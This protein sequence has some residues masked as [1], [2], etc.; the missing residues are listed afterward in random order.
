MTGI[1]DKIMKR[2]AAHGR[3]QWVCTPKDFLDFGS[4]QAIDQA[5]SR[6][7][8]AGRL[9]RLSQGLYDMPRASGVLKQVAP[10]D[11]DAAVEAIARR[12]GV[13]IMPDGLVAANQLGLT[14]AVP[15]KAV[16]VT[17][18]SSRTVKMAGRTIQFRHASPSAMQ[19][20]GRPAAPVAQALRWLGPAAVKDASVLSTLKRILPDKVKRDLFQNSRVLPGWALP[21]VREL[22]TDQVAAV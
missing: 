17:D 8:K 14:N 6:L 1:A 9:R 7:V 5:L 13:R 21:L 11:M 20:S 2:V 10:P 16:Y 19:W 22:Q 12:D 4:R 15:A 18:G 3:G